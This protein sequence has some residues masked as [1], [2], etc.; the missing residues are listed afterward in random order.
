[1]KDE[2]KELKEKFLEY[3]S[4]TPIKRWAAASIGRDEDTVRL[5]EKEDSEFSERIKLAKATEILKRYKRV[6]EDK[7]ILEK[8]DNENFGA[9]LDMTSGGEKLEGLVIIKD[10]S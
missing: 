1:M 5:W 2:K 3:Y 7:W 8:L 6:R 10:G 9:K 4:Q